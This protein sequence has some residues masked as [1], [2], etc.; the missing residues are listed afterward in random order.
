MP[1]LYGRGIEGG[2]TEPA[3]IVKFHPLPGKDRLSDG[4]TVLQ[5]K[6]DEVRELID[7][8]PYA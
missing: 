5:S 8:S 1:A 6:L 2:R 4:A 3:M 7:V